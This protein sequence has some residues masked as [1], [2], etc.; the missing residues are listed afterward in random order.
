MKN[1]QVIIIGGGLAGLT[2]AIHLCQKE[3][4]VILIEKEQ[5]PHHK[6]CGEYLS[7]EVIPYLNSLNLNIEALKAPIINRVEYSSVSGKLISCD[8]NMGGIGISRY[9]L[10]HLLYKKAE[11]SGCT[12]INSLAVE[13]EYTN[14]Q[15]IVTTSQGEIITSE[16]VLGAYG[17]RSNLDK[18]LSR[19]FIQEQSGWLAVK[20]HYKTNSE[21]YSENLVSLH[22]FSG[23]YCGL[24]KTELNTINVCYLASYASFKNYKNT[25]DYKEKVL[26]KNPHLRKFFNNAEMVFDKELSIAQV[27]F[28]KKSMIENHI[29]MIGDSAGLIHPL[30]GNG[31]AMAIHSAKIASEGILRFYN[32]KNITRNDVE[33]N[34]VQEWNQKFSSRLKAGRVLQKVFLN[35]TLTNISQGFLNRVPQLLPH[36]IKRTHGQPIHV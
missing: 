14:E 7:R 6:V 29:L 23:G 2:A 10:D 11:N 18:K 35:K 13:I 5:Y 8:L 19:K 17:K 28:D 16:F 15:F 9:S 32:L 36:I 30:C 26:M 4:D 20:A 33:N 34:Y 24:S 25:E 1:T 12:I 22:N 21:F 31:M 27:C 3:I